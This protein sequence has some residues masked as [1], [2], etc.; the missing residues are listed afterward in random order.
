LLVSSINIVKALALSSLGSARQLAQDALA[1]KRALDSPQKKL[2]KAQAGAEIQHEA[3]L[4]AEKPLY[5]AKSSTVAKLDFKG[6]EP[7]SQQV[8][9]P[10]SKALTPPLFLWLVP[11]PSVMEQD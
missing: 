5:R 10:V 3:L 11:K 8:N 1:P 2:Q 7:E 4:L 9:P 6:K